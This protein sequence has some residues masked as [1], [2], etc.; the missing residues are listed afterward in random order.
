MTLPTLSLPLSLL[1]RRAPWHGF[2]N[3]N[4]SSLSLTMCCSLSWLCQ[5]LAFLS[6]IYKALLTSVFIRH[7]SLASFT[8]SKFLQPVI[9]INSTF[10]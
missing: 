3:A 7:A 10:H 8:R 1:Q 2:A 4:P 9:A 6:V 5:C